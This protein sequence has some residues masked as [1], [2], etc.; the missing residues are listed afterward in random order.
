[1]SG[2]APDPALALT[3]TLLLASIFAAAAVGKLRALDRFEGVVR[4]Y[5]LLPDRLV[6]PAVHGLPLVE[7]AAAAALI[8]PATRPLAAVVL[9][10]LLLVFAA[11]MAVNLRR[12]RDDIDCGC[13]LGLLKQRISWA[14]VARNLL[15]AGFGSALV[16]GGGQT[17]PLGG[18]DGLTVVAA[19]LSLLILYAAVGRL[20]GLAPAGL[21]G[22]R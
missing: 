21:K 3:A 20:F 10:L 7:L 11:A 22:A 13:H 5:R 1:V 6:R 15:L 9:I 18:L 2:V 14:L 12:G 8:L 17:R 16:S 19:T 4:N